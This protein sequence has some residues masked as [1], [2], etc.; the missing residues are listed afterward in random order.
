MRDKNKQ[1][2]NEE[3]WQAYIL[4]AKDTADTLK[5][6][7]SKEVAERW[8]GISLPKKSVMINNFMRNYTIPMLTNALNNITVRQ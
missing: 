4:E 8:Y 1:N 2:W 5:K 6:Q 3:T 7:G